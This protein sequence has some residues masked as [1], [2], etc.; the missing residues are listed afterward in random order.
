MATFL[1]RIAGNRLRIDLELGTL[2]TENT[3]SGIAAGKLF[4]SNTIR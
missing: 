2:A 1:A 3:G 4:A